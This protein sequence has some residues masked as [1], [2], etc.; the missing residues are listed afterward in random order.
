MIYLI[1]ALLCSAAVSIVLK[2]CDRMEYSRYGMLTVNYMTCLAAFLITLP[3]QGLPEY[4]S[5]MLFCLSL[6]AVNGLL[7][8]G[9]MVMNQVN[10]RRN[11]AILQ[12]TFAR[13]GVMVPTIIS[14]AFFGERPSPGQIT[15]IAMVLLAVCIM[16]IRK[17]SGNR[18]VKKPA[19]G[20]LIMGLLLG[21]V[22]DSMSKIFE[23][24]G[25]RSLDSWFMGG[26]FLTALIISSLITA[27]GKGRIGK[28]EA[29]MGAALGIPNYI[30]SLFLLKALASVSAYIAYPTYSV[31]AIIVV[32]AASA[33]IFRE[34]ISRWSK[35]G[36]AMIIVAILLLN[37]G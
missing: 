14:I 26:T 12:S 20:L 27:S 31:G 37:I 18:T 36:V 2:Y 9:C 30:S 29:V 34:R 7:Y 6:A 25:K 21:G 16:N 8:L 13:L 17:E 35:A 22:S 15:A 4:G 3:G 24:F 32:I 28:R 5:D 10:V 23:E 11:G 19:V 1:L 33:L